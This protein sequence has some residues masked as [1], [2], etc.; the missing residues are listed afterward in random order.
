MP[1]FT[2]AGPQELVFPH[3]QALDAIGTLVLTPGETYDW[4]DQAPVGPSWWWTPVAPAPPAPPP[5]APVAAP[6]AAPVTPAPAP[7]PAEPPAEG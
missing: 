7:A 5:A 3:Q 1:S 6:A 2:Y 4:G